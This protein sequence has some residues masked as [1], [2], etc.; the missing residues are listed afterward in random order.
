M[1]N[2]SLIKVGNDY[3]VRADDQSILRVASRRRAAS[4]ISDAVSLLNAV[5]APV[6]VQDAPS[7]QREE[8]EAS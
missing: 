2:Y 8:P 1:T 7:I 4:L 3:I 5:D 6:E